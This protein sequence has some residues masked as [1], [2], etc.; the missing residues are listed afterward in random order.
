[1]PFTSGIANTHNDLFTQLNTFATGLSWTSNRL[2]LSAGEAA[3]NQSGQ[4]FLSRGNLFVGFAWNPNVAD[5]FGMYQATGYDA[6]IVPNDMPGA[7]GHGF[8]GQPTTSWNGFSS[9]SDDNRC[10]RAPGLGP[11]N[12][13][14][15]ASADGVGEQYIHCAIE[16]APGEYRHFGFG[17]LDKSWDFTGGEYV[18]GHQVE[19]NGNNPQSQQILLSSVTATT[20]TGHDAADS[21]RVSGLPGQGVGGKYGTFNAWTSATQQ[22]D[23]DGDPLASLYGGAPGGKIG[24]SFNNLPS[25]SGDGFLPLT[26]NAIFYRE[27]TST[28]DVDYLLGFQP[29]VRTLNMKNFTAQDTF[30][31]GSD[32]WQVFP[33]VLKQFTNTSTEESRNLGVAYRR[34]A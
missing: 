1:M 34:F 27:V 5:T 32:T 25:S 18:Y 13:F 21:I 6:S 4:L 29:D 23:E 24:S 17:N 9:T 12:Y 10:V 30:T 7:L 28:P 26:P 16:I 2:R 15:F 14:F 22:S 20:A 19:S 3:N 33:S 11:F 31:V 8:G